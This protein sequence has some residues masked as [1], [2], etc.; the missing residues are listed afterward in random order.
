MF[1]ILDTMS[2]NRSGFG[3]LSRYVYRRKEDLRNDNEAYIRPPSLMVLAVTNSIGTF[4][5]SHMIVTVFGIK[6]IG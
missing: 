2:A 1:N 4:V 5:C 6:S 3:R